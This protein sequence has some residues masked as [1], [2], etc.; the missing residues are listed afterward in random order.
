VFQPLP[1]PLRLPGWLLLLVFTWVAPAFGTVLD[2]EQVLRLSEAAMGREIP[3]SYRFVDAAG[4]VLT[5][6]EL[7]GRPLVISLVYSSCY[8]T[9]PM[10]TEY[11]AKVVG[12]ARDALGEDSFTV[13]TIGFDTANDTPVRMRQ[14]A[15]ERRIEDPR[16]H[17]LSADAGTIA[18]LVRD[19]GFSYASSAKGFDHMTQATVIDR[20]GRVYRQV[21]GDRFPAPALVEPL[22]ELVFDTPPKAGLVTALSNEVRLLCTVFDPASGRYRFDYSIF[23]EIFAAVTCLSAAAFFMIR[24]WWRAR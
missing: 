17:F 10:V 20:D 13:L 12:M 9:C 18:G 4:G 7:R 21:Y 1:V 16:W 23:I 5:L 24:T 3:G 14:F 2:R 15:R 22:K 8:H 11:L 6:E 19:L